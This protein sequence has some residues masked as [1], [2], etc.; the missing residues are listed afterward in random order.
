M[1]CIVPDRVTISAGTKFRLK[2]NGRGTCAVPYEGGFV[3]IGGCCNH[4]KVD[5]LKLWSKCLNFSFLTL[6]IDMMWTVNTWARCPTSTLWDSITR[7]L[8]LPRNQEN[9][10]LSW[11]PL[12]LWL[13]LLSGAFASLTHSYFRVWLWPEDLSEKAR[14][15][16]CRQLTSGQ[17]EGRSRGKQPIFFDTFVCPSNDFHI[18]NNYPARLWVSH[19]WQ[20]MRRPMLVFMLSKDCLGSWCGLERPTWTKK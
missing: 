12:Q 16:T 11:K 13:N 3:Q 15:C 17:L 5:R 7:A 19:H 10:S 9:R 4:G 2:N 14:R 20:S 8:L 18:F 6:L 1:Y